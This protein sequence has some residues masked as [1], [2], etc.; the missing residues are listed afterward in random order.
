MYCHLSLSLSLSQMQSA[1]D[2]S[3]SVPEYEET[4]DDMMRNH[5]VNKLQKKWL[6]NKYRKSI[7]TN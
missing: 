1:N 2:D 4:Y 7:S 5:I 6:F 3:R